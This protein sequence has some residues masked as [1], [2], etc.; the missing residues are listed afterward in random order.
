[1]YS[2]KFFLCY[3]P[4]KNL[5][6]K[7]QLSNNSNQEPFKQ[8]TQISDNHTETRRT[9]LFLGNQLLYFIHH[10][11][12]LKYKTQELNFQRKYSSLHN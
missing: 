5:L 8:L 4:A 6:S 2:L 1:M 12:F 3:Y 7:G 11:I 10:I 9:E